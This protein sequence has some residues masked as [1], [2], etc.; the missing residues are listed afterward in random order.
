MWSVFVAWALV[1]AAARL[2]SLPGGPG[3]EA[4]RFWLRLRC[5][6]LQQ[7]QFLSAWQD[8]RGA[9]D[10]PSRGRASTRDAA[11]KTAYATRALGTRLWREHSCLPQRDSSRCPADQGWPPG[12]GCGFA[13]LRRRRSFFVACVGAPGRVEKP[14]ALMPGWPLQVVR[15]LRDNRACGVP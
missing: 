9:W 10:R 14:L 1:P 13:A 2:I 11:G 5:S 6:V 4:R 15:L 12:I 3:K 8:F 7:L